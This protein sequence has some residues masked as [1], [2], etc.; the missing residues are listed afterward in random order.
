M[1]QPA[2]SINKGLA[3]G[4]AAVGIALGAVGLAVPVQAQGKPN[5]VVIWG[6]DI[7]QSNL[8]TYTEGLM[9]YKTPNIDRIASEGM[10]FTDYY[11]EQSCTAGRSAFITGQAVFRTGMSKVGL[12]GAKQGLSH[13]D[14]TIAELLKPLGY[15]TGQFGKNHLGDRN[16]FLPTVHGFD[17]FYGNLYHLN[18]EEEPEETDYPKDPK[19][20][21]KYGPRGVMDCKASETDDP[22]EDP[23]F[24]KMGKQVCKDTGPL[25][26]KRMETIDDDIAAR[27][28]DFMQRQTKAG[29]PFFLWVNFTHMHLWTHT[30]PESLGQA[31]EFQGFYH[32]TMIDHDTN[33]G[34]ILDEIDKLGISKN[35]IVMYGTDNGPHMNAWPDAATTPFRNEKGTGWEGGFRVPAMVRWPGKIKPGTVSNEIMSNLDWAPTLLAAAGDPD[36]KQKLLKGHKAAGKTFKV[37]LDGYNFLPYLTGKEKTGPRV[38]YF[39]FSDDGDLLALRHGNWKMHFKV[40]D[41]PGTLE[42]WQRKFRDLRLPYLFNL[43]TDPYERATITSNTYWDWYIRHVFLLVPAQEKVGEFLGTFKDYPPRQKAASFTID[44]VL[45][46]MQNAH[47]G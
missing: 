9:G 38:E 27:A 24:G 44:Q 18:A 13:K 46:K 45:Q 42:V 16:E 1:N 15:A 36:I 8:S 35:T 6:D 31:G 26:R 23:R 34:S 28:Q 22:T 37:H 25:T 39:Y 43:R 5:I 4:F 10:K 41:Q 20:R 2:K 40:Q 19:F 21:A 11:A 3:A 33:V 14:P 32:D 12:P 47:G 29:K 7:G 17:E 30:K